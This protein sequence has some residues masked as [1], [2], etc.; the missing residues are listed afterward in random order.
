MNSYNVFC[1]EKVHPKPNLSV[2]CKQTVWRHMTEIIRN[3]EN[4][5]LFLKMKW[6][7]VVS[8]ADSTFCS[9]IHFKK[10]KD[11]HIQFNVFQYK[12]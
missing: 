3:H 8:P 10:K 2:G 1:K 9:T 5:K 4:I 7:C 11:I 6:E 12:L